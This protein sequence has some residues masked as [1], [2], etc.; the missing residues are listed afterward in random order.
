MALLHV[1][2]GMW[3]MAIFWVIALLIVFLTVS[4]HPAIKKIRRSEAIIYPLVMGGAIL[5]A[6]FLRTFIFGLYTVPSESMERT[7]MPGDVVWVNKT[8]AGPRLPSSPYELPWIGLVFWFLQD[9]KENDIHKPW[10]NNHRLKGYSSIKA[11]EIIVFNHPGSG[12][13]FIKRCVGTPGDTLNII[14]GE[15]KINGRKLDTPNALFNT[16]V[17]YTNREKAW[18][19]IRE[20]IQ[21]PHNLYQQNRKDQINLATTREEMKKLRKAEFVKTAHIETERPDSSW[22][23]YPGEK[24]TE[25]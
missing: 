14:D 2:Y 19:E 16:R 3:W 7:L 4:E 20:I 24:E 11:G 17:K 21:S 10:W 18:K 6:V 9:Q 25:W 5:L 8:L 13:V 1:I 23:L 22:T 15:V 12:K